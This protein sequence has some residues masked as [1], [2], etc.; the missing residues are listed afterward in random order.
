M[1]ARAP[2]DSI[3]GWIAAWKLEYGPWSKFMF[4][5]GFRDGEAKVIMPIVGWMDVILAV[6]TLVRPN[7]IFLAWMV[8]WAFSTA[9]VRPFS[10]GFERWSKPMSD[11]AL[12][13]FVERASNWACPLALL[14]HVKSDGYAVEDAI[15]AGP[16]FAALAP[17]DATL[18]GYATTQLAA[19]MA[20]AFALPWFVVVP[21]LRARGPDPAK[22]D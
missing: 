4:A 17:L 10:A 8:V 3:V 12:W 22:A 16:L 15:G 14:A 6:V 13:G 2:R 18:S 7:E 19:F 11:N 20:A 5:A 9:L 1:P 21:L